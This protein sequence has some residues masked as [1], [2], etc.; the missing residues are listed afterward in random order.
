MVNK[1]N[2]TTPIRPAGPVKSGNAGAPV[3]GGDFAAALARE[4]E[5]QESLKISSHAQKRLDSSQ[6]T[7]TDADIKRLDGA[8]A[9]ASE[10]G[11]AQSLI[12][13]DNVAFVVSV[14]NKVVITAVDEARTKEGVFTNIDSVVIA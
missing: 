7:L 12:M 11:S 3:K 13:L 5:R 4:T 6:V 14:K 1:L 9:R 8:V 10:K 2:L